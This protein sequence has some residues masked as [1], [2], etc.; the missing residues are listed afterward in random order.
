MTVCKSFDGSV[1]VLRDGRRLPF[2]VLAE[3]E[4]AVP[5]ADKKDIRQRVD[6]AKAT[7]AAR[8]NFK[9]PAAKRVAA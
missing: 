2:R 8:P 7:Q 3:G 6:E 1:T 5:V 4:A 9:P